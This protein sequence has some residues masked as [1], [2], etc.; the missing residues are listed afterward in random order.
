MKLTVIALTVAAGVV[1]A[2]AAEPIELKK[3]GND[4]Y[5][6]MAGEKELAELMPDNWQGNLN[7]LSTKNKT[8]CGVNWPH[9]LL[10]SEGKWLTDKVESKGMNLVEFKT[11]NTS[12]SVIGYKG[13]WTFRDYCISSESHCVWYDAASATQVHLV[14]ARLEILKDL[15]DISSTWIEFMTPENSYTMVAA[16]TKGDKIVT[17]DVSGTGANANMHYLDGYEFGNNGWITIYG[18]R[19]GQ[20]ACVAMVPISSS[21]RIRPRINNGHVDNIEMHMLDPRKRNFLTKGRTF[22]LEYL[23]IVGPDQKDWKWID[24]VVQNARTFMTNNAALLENP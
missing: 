22:S 2:T 11:L 15:P 18:A 17:V 5:R 4:D 6:L 8:V 13:K 16:R 23:L 10:Y 24:S 14:K 9:F 1:C 3:A 12:D 7:I 19:R 21:G 20:D